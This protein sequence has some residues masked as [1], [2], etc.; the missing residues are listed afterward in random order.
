MNIKQ[1]QDKVAKKPDGTLK[2]VYKDLARFPKVSDKYE[3]VF[4]ET[5]GEMIKVSMGEIKNIME[6]I[7]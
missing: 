3:S 1:R 6:D 2:S 4:T 7:R 5:Y